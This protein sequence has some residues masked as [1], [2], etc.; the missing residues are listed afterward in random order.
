MLRHIARGQGGVSV[1]GHAQQ[2]QGGWFAAASAHGVGDV[3]TGEI[4]DQ[5]LRCYASILSARTAEFGGSAP[6]NNLWIRLA[7]SANSD[8]FMQRVSVAFD[9]D[10]Y[11]VKF[12]YPDVR[13]QLQQIYSQD[14][15]A[16]EKMILSYVLGSG[17]SVQQP[18]SL[19][20]VKE[21]LHSKFTS[22]AAQ[23]MDGAEPGM[24]RHNIQIIDDITGE[25]RLQSV[26]L[27]RNACGIITHMFAAPNAQEDTNTSATGASKVVTVRDTRYASCVELT[28]TSA[29]HDN[30]TSRHSHGNQSF[31]AHMARQ[32]AEDNLQGAYLEVFQVG[33][34]AWI[35]PL[36]MSA[37]YPVPINEFEHVACGTLSLHRNGGVYVDFAPANMLRVGVNTH[38]AVYNGRIL[39]RAPRVEDFNGCDVILSKAEG[40]NVLYVLK[41]ELLGTLVPTAIDLSRIPMLKA[42]HQEITSK[43]NVITTEKQLKNLIYVHERLLAA[44]AMKPKRP[45]EVVLIDLWEMHGFPR[46]ATE[47]DLQNWEAIADKYVAGDHPQY[48]VADLHIEMQ[49]LRDIVNNRNLQVRERHAAFELLTVIVQAKDVFGFFVSVLELSYGYG[50]HISANT[51]PATED[52]V[53]RSCI[54]HGLPARRID[55]NAVDTA[56][57]SDNSAAD[58]RVSQSVKAFAHFSKNDVIIVGHEY[59][60][61]MPD[62]KD[63]ACF[64]DGVC[65]REPSN[66]AFFVAWDDIEKKAIFAAACEQYLKD[67]MKPIGGMNDEFNAGLTGLIAGVNDESISIAEIDSLLLEFVPQD[68]T[69]AT[70][71]ECVGKFRECYLNEMR[72][73][74]VQKAMTQE[75]F[76]QSADRVTQYNKDVERLEGF[77]TE[78]FAPEDRGAVMLLLTNTKAYVYQYCCDRLGSEMQQIYVAKPRNQLQSMLGKL[79]LNGLKVEDIVRAVGDVTS[80]SQVMASSVLTNTSLSSQA[81]SAAVA[82]GF[83]GGVGG[84]NSRTPVTIPQRMSPHGLRRQQ[85]VLQPTP[86]HKVGRDTSLGVPAS[87]SA[88]VVSANS[89]GAAVTYGVV[90]PNIGVVGKN[91]WGLGAAAGGDANRSPPVLS[92]RTHSEAALDGAANGHAPLEVIG[93]NLWRAK[94]ARIASAERQWTRTARGDLASKGGEDSFS[95][96]AMGRHAILAIAAVDEAIKKVHIPRPPTGRQNTRSSTG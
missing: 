9:P 84:G 92:V 7:N 57:R 55:R 45:L 11:Q 82:A 1:V 63:V 29:G 48:T 30:K 22:A 8:E 64:L 80:R 60:S 44:F 91:V 13:G 41:K 39:N 71:R 69:T 33:P 66:K 35:S 20:Q 43:L 40:I 21:L 53:W 19:Q 3:I 83:A 47:E 86:P 85:H 81:T 65:Y 78:H 94:A 26:I 79:I 42:L 67:A 46:F 6:I 58:G 17:T 68:E 75:H 14:M 90:N 88:G 5:Q 28:R 56:V 77:V 18:L 15:A 25:E 38:H 95:R 87:A 62:G 70:G 74:G 51:L 96:A 4:L 61:E 23:R 12:M 52:Q 49:R 54:Q 93:T 89:R 24:E 32:V 37:K 72:K 36:G 59:T 34:D 16:H 31:A 27:K 2:K 50:W 73:V 10:E 76:C